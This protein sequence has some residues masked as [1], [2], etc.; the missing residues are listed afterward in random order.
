MLTNYI[1]TSRALRRM[2][3]NYFHYIFE[4]YVSHLHLHGYKPDTIRCYCQALE[5]FGCWIKN[6]KISKHSIDQTQL[7]AFIKHLTSCQCSFPRTKDTKTIK[8]AINQLFKISPSTSQRTSLTSAEADIIQGFADYL[9]NVCGAA[10]NTIVYRKRYA[11]AFL[12]YVRLQDISQIEKIIPQ[13]IISFIKQFSSHYASGSV[14]VVSTS[15]RSF[16][17]YAVFL[18]YKVK[19]LLGAVPN[20]PNWRLSQV[21]EFLAQSEI[22]KLLNVFNQLEDSG[23]RN[24]AMA[25]CFTDLG[26]RCCEVADIKMKDI[27]WHTGVLNICRTKTKQI[28][29]LPLTK[30]LGE[31]I[32]NYLLYGRPNSKSEYIFV[33]HRAP[34]GEAVRTE[35]VRAVIRRSFQKAGFSPVPSPHILRR[36]LATHL[37]NAGSSLKEIADILGHKSI[38]TTMIYTKV[39]LPHLSLVAMPWF[40]GC[41]E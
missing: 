27:N 24:Y 12:K 30:L 36:S 3:A 5:H 1:N 32:S 38:N 2:H 31:S 33:H 17:K 11:F 35:T 14:G 41:N 7:H 40:G 28:I 22:E 25:R 29:Q 13:Q 19:N 4:D 34:L 20:I 15:L 21:P 8:A 26:L 39:D 23:K 10:M 9:I 37:L 6:R 16:L 18:G